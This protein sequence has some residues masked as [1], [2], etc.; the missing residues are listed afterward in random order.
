ML[1]T[2]RTG[3]RRGVVGE[4]GTR[5]VVVVKSVGNLLPASDSGSRVGLGQRPEVPRG[6]LGGV[7]GDGSAGEIADDIAAA[8]VQPI[9][10]GQCDECARVVRPEFDDAF[11]EGASDFR[12]V[13]VR[14]GGDDE[15]VGIGIP[16]NRL[17]CTNERREIGALLEGDNRGGHVSRG[18][19]AGVRSGRGR[20]DHGSK[21]TGNA[22]GAHLRSACHFRCRAMSASLRIGFISKSPAVVSL[23]RESVAAALPTAA[24]SDVA[25]DALSKL[26]ACAL[27][28]IDA[29]SDVAAAGEIARQ[30]RAGASRSALVFVVTARD[31][32]LATTSA[33]VG[34]VEQIETRLLGP[35]M[36]GTV[37]RAVGGSG[38][39]DDLLAARDELRK[40]Q[41]LL[42]AGEIALGL[43]HAMNNPLTA[44][45]AEA[46]LLEMETLPTE[47]AT[48]VRRIIES[49]RRLVALVRKLDVVAT[50]KV[51]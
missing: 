30:L 25:P 13:A 37:E 51:G 1:V 38:W 45:L 17:Q 47:I 39:N 6:T 28:F 26:P 16:G 32:L 22:A 33:S 41:R 50:K 29:T 11:V 24:F 31:E 42:A 36:A 12:A 35:A 5:E 43:Q 7:G 46:Q 14:F 48:A 4:Q 23:V 44:V 9:G 20:R 49:T 27:I 19:R 3:E 21:L 2:L 40:T 34:A 15:A 8:A 10:I 18:P